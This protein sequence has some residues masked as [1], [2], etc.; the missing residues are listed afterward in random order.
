MPENRLSNF[1]DYN[2]DGIDVPMGAQNPFPQD[3]SIETEVDLDAKFLRT[4]IGVPPPYRMPTSIDGGGS[5]FG[6][7]P[8]IEPLYDETFDQLAAAIACANPDIPCLVLPP[9]KVAFEVAAAAFAVSKGYLG[10]YP[11]V[12]NC[13]IL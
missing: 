3:R 11:E 2:E 8:A 6:A 9:G 4:D 5:T 12:G 7:L 10:I 1:C 13:F